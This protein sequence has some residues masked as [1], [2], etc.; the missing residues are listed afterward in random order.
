M[1]MPKIE[2]F[3]SLL[4]RHSAILTLISVLGFIVWSLI[5]DLVI[6]PQQFNMALLRLEKEIHISYLRTQEDNMEQFQRFITLNRN[7][8]R[9]PTDKDFERLDEDIQK[10]KDEI[11]REELALK[12]EPIITV[13]GKRGE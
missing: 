3:E 12:L 4:K 1:T 8:Y 10:K 11:A 2:V 5:R 13:K 6:T 9:A 7:G